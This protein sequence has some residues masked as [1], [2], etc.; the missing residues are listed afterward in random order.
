MYDL[1]TETYNPCV[2]SDKTTKKM[3]DFCAIDI[4]QYGQGAK[5]DHYATVSEA[6]ESFYMKKAAGESIRQK[7]GD[8]LKTVSNNLDRCRTQFKLVA[9]MEA[10]WDEMETI[11]AETAKSLNYEM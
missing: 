7:C 6:V 9:D 8:L 5:T 1:K 4:A 3:I 10:H 11:V 2:I